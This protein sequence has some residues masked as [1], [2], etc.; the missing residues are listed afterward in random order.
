[1]NHRQVIWKDGAI[2]GCHIRILE[3]HED[4]RGWLAEFFRQD[5]LPESLHPRMGYLSVTRP[6]VARG[7]HEHVHQ[8]DLFL[9]FSGR[10]RV[11][12]WD[13]RVHSPSYGHHLREEFGVLRPATVLVPPGVVHGY[14]NIGQTSAWIVNCPNRL[15]AGEGKQE[16]VDEVRYENAS[17]TSYQ[18]D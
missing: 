9:F 8:T 4:P 12:L 11:H 6:G 13:A 10:F 1:M 15:Y 16:E 2:E 18:L 14:R 17:D 5:E 7:P 3:T